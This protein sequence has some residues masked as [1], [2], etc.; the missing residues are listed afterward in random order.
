MCLIYY[1]LKINCFTA[2]LSVFFKKMDSFYYF[3]NY[4]QFSRCLLTDLILIFS[5]INYFYFDFFDNQKHITEKIFLAKHFHL[6][7]KYYFL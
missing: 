4:Y 1:C 7:V 3:L 5:S 2:E 6:D